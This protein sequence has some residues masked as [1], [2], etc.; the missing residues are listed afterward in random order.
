M[1]PSRTE[2]ARAIV[3]HYALEMDGDEP[4]AEQDRFKAVAID[5]SRGSAADYIANTSP[6][7]LM[8]LDLMKTCKAKIQGGR[9]RGCVGVD[10]GDTA[11]KD[12]VKRF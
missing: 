4:G 3:R 9:A 12:F 1:H 2:E 6:R 10:V 5:W 8:D 7:T 11:V